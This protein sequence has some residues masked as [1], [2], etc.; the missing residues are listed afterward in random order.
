MPSESTSFQ[1]TKPDC[2]VCSVPSEEAARQELRSKRRL[3]VLLRPGHAS[4]N[5]LVR[6]EHHY[7]PG[8]Q[9]QERRHEPEGDKGERSK[10]KASLS[11][12]LLLDSGFYKSVFTLCRKP[13]LLHASA[14]WER[15]PWRC[16]T[17][18]S[19][20]SW[21]VFWPHPQ[22]K[23]PPWCRSRPRRRRWSDT[24]GCLWS[25]RAS[26][27]SLVWCWVWCNEPDRWWA[28]LTCHQVVLQD[29]LFNHVVGH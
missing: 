28:F 18:P 29:E 17:G 6:H 26:V 22:E 13:R 8:A 24:A 3:P 25:S 2:C 10:K 14:W 9:S 12:S 11:N 19:P 1:E 15:S 16:C 27:T 5:L 4:L 7:V 23:P 20:S 21:S